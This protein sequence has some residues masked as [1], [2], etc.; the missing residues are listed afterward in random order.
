MAT[1]LKFLGKGDWDFTSDSGVLAT[2]GECPFASRYILFALLIGPSKSG[3]SGALLFHIWLRIEKAG[4]FNKAVFGRHGAL[5]I[6][7]LSP[8]EAMLWT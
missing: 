3:G 1:V 4:W 5:C 7:R 2:N 8:G 6:Q